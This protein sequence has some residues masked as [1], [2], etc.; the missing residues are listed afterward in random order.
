METMKT[1]IQ[2]R[3]KRVVVPKKNFYDSDS[4]SDD[5]S[6]VVIVK[7]V[8]KKKSKDDFSSDAC[9]DDSSTDD[10][11]E[12]TKNTKKRKLKSGAG[13]G[14]GDKN[15][16]GKKK[17]RVGDGGGSSS[18]SSSKR[19]TKEKKKKKAG[20]KVK[21][22]PP[23]REEIKDPEYDPTPEDESDYGTVEN[24]GMKAVKSV[25]H[26][27]P[28]Y[29]FDAR[30]YARFKEGEE[31]IAANAKIR[32][33]ENGLPS[34]ILT[35]NIYHRSLLACR[36]TAFIRSPPCGWAAIWGRRPVFAQPFLRITPR[37]ST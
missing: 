26:E 17:Q 21:Y 12:L 15:N 14:A 27:G 30:A 9:S 37:S 28:R 34:R 19:S 29:A 5:D 23:Q 13:A 32:V 8:A 36:T 2:Q 18:S 20:K 33:V 6:P 16:R 3:A 35:H 10:E 1:S 31:Q 24:E 11:Q 22:T 25:L 7:V 4:S